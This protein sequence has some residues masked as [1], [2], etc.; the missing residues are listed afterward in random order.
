[1]WHKSIGITVLLLS[2]VRLGWRIIHPAPTLPA[3]VRGWER[4]AAQSVHA[5]FYVLMIGMPL[6]G[7]AWV[8]SSPLIKIHPTVLYGVIPWPALP[9]PG[10]SADQLHAAR[11]AFQLTHESLALVAYGAIF[12]H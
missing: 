7:W 12:L 10:L 6:S 5:L 3:Y 8:S 9:L 1:M 11:Q 4:F 2:L